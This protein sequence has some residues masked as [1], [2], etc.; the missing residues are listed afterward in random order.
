MQRDP[1]AGHDTRFP[2]DH[3]S[4]ALD[5]Y[6]AEPSL[7][8]L[9]G[10]LMAV[11]RQPVESESQRD[12]TM[13][14][15]LKHLGKRIPFIRTLHTKYRNLTFS[16]SQTYWERVYAT[17]GNSGHGSYGRL[18]RFKA[19][20]INSFVHE[21]DINSV[22]EFGCGDGNQLSL[23]Q[24]PSYVGLDVSRTALDMCRERFKRDASKSFFLYD[25]R[26]FVDNG[27]VFFSDLA[28]S[29]DVIYHLIE[30]DIY[31][32][33]MAHLFNAADRFVIVYSTDDDWKTEGHVRERRFTDWVSDNAV[34]WRLREKTANRYPFDPLR[35]AETSMSEFF[36]FEKSC[37]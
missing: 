13:M 8:V 15:R 1:H 16:G 33:Y 14:K 32:R 7:A 20:F 9:H 5:F 12:T 2:R 30:D 37:K 18:A 4:F 29:L 10:Q 36:V 24:Y 35:P 26:A 6:L 11:G 23:S 3:Y 19:E 34:T 27:H 22:I 31:D 28:L 17:G 21:Q 25:P